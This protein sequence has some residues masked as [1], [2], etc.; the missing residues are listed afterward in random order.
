MKTLLKKLATIAF[1]LVLWE[2]FAEG[3][4]VTAIDSTDH[5]AFCCFAF[6]GGSVPLLSLTDTKTL[7]ELK[8]TLPRTNRTSLEDIM[9]IMME[10]KE[11]AV[12]EKL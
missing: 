11:Y 5:E 1:F 3:Q 6:D 10:D 8:I 7:S 2:G 9:Y 4:T 12:T